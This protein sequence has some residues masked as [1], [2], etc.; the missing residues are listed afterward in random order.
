MRFMLTIFHSPHWVFK[1][2]FNLLAQFSLPELTSVLNHS[3][4]LSAPDSTLIILSSRDAAACLE[5]QRWR[6]GAQR[7]PSSRLVWATW[8][9]LNLLHQALTLNARCS[10]PPFHLLPSC[11]YHTHLLFFNLH[12][13]LPS[14]RIR[15]ASRRTTSSSQCDYLH[16]TLV[17]F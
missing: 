5:F 17:V 14:V 6:D 10:V 12:F 16:L 3:K 4:C 7:N 2:L 13:L 15:A 11:A 8:Q 9:T 1:Y